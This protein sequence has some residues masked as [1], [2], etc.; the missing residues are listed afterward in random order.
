[1]V[2]ANHWTEQGDSNRGIREKTE[3]TEGGCNTIG[4]RAVST[5][6]TPPDL[7]GSKSPTYEYISR[8]P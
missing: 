4:K 7:T 3:G 1:M 6:Q 5:N 8:E 2:A